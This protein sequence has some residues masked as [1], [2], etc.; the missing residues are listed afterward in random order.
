MAAFFVDDVD[1]A[2]LLVVSVILD[3]PG[4]SH[5]D[6]RLLVANAASTPLAD[7]IRHAVFLVVSAELRRLRTFRAVPRQ[8][9]ATVSSAKLG[10]LALFHAV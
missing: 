10:R 8:R 1:N 7:E 2:I 3:R 4:T 5:A 9:G 6:R